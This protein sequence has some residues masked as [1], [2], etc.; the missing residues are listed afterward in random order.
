MCIISWFSVIIR[1]VSSTR[2]DIV[3]STRFLQPQ[4]LISNFRKIS[5][6]KVN[7]DLKTPKNSPILIAFNLSKIFS[8]S[9]LSL[10]NGR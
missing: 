8:T 9:R 7:S 5:Y 6:F 4:I 3:S 2:F 10:E 1:L